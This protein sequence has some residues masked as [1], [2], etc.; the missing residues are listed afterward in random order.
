M[1]EQGLA[2]W[3]KLL[4]T[5][6]VVQGPNCWNLALVDIGI[7]DHKRFSSANE[8]REAINYFCQV[9][10]SSQRTR[11]DIGVID[12]DEAYELHAFVVVDSK[13]A[14]TKDFAADR[15]EENISYRVEPISTVIA[16]YIQSPSSAQCK[17]A[18][19][20]EQS[21]CRS[22]LQYYRCDRQKIGD[23]RDQ[24]QTSMPKLSENLG[25]SEEVLEKYLWGQAVAQDI[26]YSLINLNEE[27]EK[28]DLK[29]LPLTTDA[30]KILRLRIL[31][32]Y[33][34]V[35]E[36]RADI[37]EANLRERFAKWAEQLR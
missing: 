5:N 3:G 21:P 23:T 35:L 36:I 1:P 8:F 30:K 34:G 15:P 20:E 13:N 29:N 37:H 33:E 19:E 22:R 25:T 7:T 10:P 26:W 11:G 16:P 24:L 17:N 6:P 27:L 9:I 31:G 18:N 2:L 32:L 12:Y 14:L 4:G 28:T